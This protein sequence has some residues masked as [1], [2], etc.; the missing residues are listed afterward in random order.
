MHLDP[1]GALQN[2]ASASLWEPKTPALSKRKRG[3][4]H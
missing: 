2:L 1:S 3:D 4:T